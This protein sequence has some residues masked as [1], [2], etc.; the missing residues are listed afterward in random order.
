[1]LG[2]ADLLV[3]IEELGPEERGR[4]SRFGVWVVHLSLLLVLGGGIVGRLTAFEGT[5]FVPQTGGEVIAEESYTQ[6][7]F[8]F[9]PQL[10]EIRQKAPDVLFVPGLA[11]Q[12]AQ[13]AQQARDTGLTSTLLGGDGFDS[14]KLR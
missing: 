11:S 5:A 4:F 8:D 14:P 10:L 12:A 6:T 1:M 7:Q 2:A 3:T 9:K 13:I